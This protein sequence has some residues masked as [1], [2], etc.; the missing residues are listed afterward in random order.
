MSYSILYMLFI[1]TSLSENSLILILNFH[2]KVM[3]TV[4]GHTVTLNKQK[5]V[6]LYISFKQLSVY[7]ICARIPQSVKPTECTEEDNLVS[8]FQGIIINLYKRKFR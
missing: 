1:F 3:T 5:N 7:N 8:I 4:I 2:Q 6:Y